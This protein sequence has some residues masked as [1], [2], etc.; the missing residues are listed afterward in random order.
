VYKATLL[1]S[2]SNTKLVGKTWETL[3]VGNGNVTW[4]GAK[5]LREGLI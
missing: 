5:E 2:K 1:S 4:T 3:E